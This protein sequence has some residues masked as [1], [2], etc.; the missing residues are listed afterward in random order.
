[1][2]KKNKVIDVYWDLST[3]EL[4]LLSLFIFGIT[5]MWVRSEHARRHLN[6]QRDAPHVIDQEVTEPVL[7]TP[8]PTPKQT[9]SY[10]IAF[11]GGQYQSPEGDT[12]YCI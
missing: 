3:R 9:C 1:M 5:L 2:M 10:V 8:T 7:V 11:M 12:F 6:L 4:V